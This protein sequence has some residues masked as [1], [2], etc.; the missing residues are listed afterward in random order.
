[1]GIAT[2]TASKA[3]AAGAG[4]APNT[5]AA[6]S[7]SSGAGVTAPSSSI[8]GAGGTADVAAVT[9]SSSEGAGA[10]LPTAGMPRGCVVVRLRTTGVEKSPE[11]MPIGP[12]RSR[13][14]A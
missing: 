4:I 10:L 3:S 8:S 6:A 12:L 7:A 9:G 2:G 5:A 11:L 13:G 14:P 1:M